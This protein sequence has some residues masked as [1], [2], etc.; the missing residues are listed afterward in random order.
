M[1]VKPGLIALGAFAMM[2][3][4]AALGG[5]AP[6]ASDGSLPPTFRTILTTKDTGARLA[7]QPVTPIGRTA[8][9]TIATVFVDPARR[10]F[11]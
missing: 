2:F 5:E 1:L 6:S 11:H 9:S 10:F 8:D 4:L 3:Q 7:E